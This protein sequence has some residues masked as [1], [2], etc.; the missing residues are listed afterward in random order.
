MVV[1]YVGSPEWVDFNLVF[2]AAAALPEATFA[3]IGATSAD[4]AVDDPPP[5][6]VFF[7]G[8]KDYT[9]VPAYVDA[10]DVAIIPFK[11]EKI[12]S[13]AD[14]VKF[15]EYFALGKPVVSTP[16]KQL[17]T[18]NDGRMLIGCRKLQRISL[19]P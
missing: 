7:L 11:T 9:S 8:R 14:P 5:A 16:N 6:N 2:R 1:G 15:Y 18:F 3:M 12:M 10:F 4:A 17:A 19:M 13:S